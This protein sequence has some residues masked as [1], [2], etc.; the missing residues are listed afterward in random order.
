[1]EPTVVADVGWEKH[2]GAVGTV[3][4]RSETASVGLPRR[5]AG[6]DIAATV[7]GLSEIALAA[8]HEADLGSPVPA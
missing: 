1:M 6:R 4:L 3:G 8:G 2:W 5:S 7:L